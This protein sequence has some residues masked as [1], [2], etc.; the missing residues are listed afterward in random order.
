MVHLLVKD[1]RLLTNYLQPLKD[2]FL[3]GRGHLH[4]GIVVAIRDAIDN[5]PGD[6]DTSAIESQFDE[7]VLG[8]L[9]LVN[10]D[11]PD[12]MKIV[13][14]RNEDPGADAGQDMGWNV[15]FE[16]GLPCSLVVTEEQIKNT[17]QKIYDFLRRL[18]TADD[19]LYR[20]WSRRSRAK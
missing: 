13:R 14:T 19:C 8:Q 17:Y 4:R 6:A 7:C 16:I 1:A 2:H 9:E 10:T 3:M 15:E 5:R 18:H 11:L 20:L 12:G